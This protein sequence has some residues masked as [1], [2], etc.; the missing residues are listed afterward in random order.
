MAPPKAVNIAHQSFKRGGH[1][2]LPK[3]ALHS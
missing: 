2:F 1:D 3:G